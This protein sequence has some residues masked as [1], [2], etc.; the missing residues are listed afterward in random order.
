MDRISKMALSNTILKI[1]LSFVICAS[2]PTICFAPPKK[3]PAGAPSQQIRG[4]GKTKTGLFLSI[5][6]SLK[7]APPKVEVGEKKHCVN[8][9]ICQR[10]RS[11]SCRPPEKR[12]D[13]VLERHDYEPRIMQFRAVSREMPPSGQYG[14]VPPPALMSDPALEVPSMNLSRLTPPYGSADDLSLLRDRAGRDQFGPYSARAPLSSSRPSGQALGKTFLPGRPYACPC[15]SDHEA[16]LRVKHWREQSL[17]PP[18]TLPPLR[19]EDLSFSKSASTAQGSFGLTKFT[20]ERASQA[21]LQAVPE[22]LISEDELPTGAR[23]E[24]SCPY[25]QSSILPPVQS[26]DLFFHSIDRSLEGSE[27][28]NTQIRGE[29]QTFLKTILSSKNTK[30]AAAVS[31]LAGLV[32]FIIGSQKPDPDPLDDEFEQESDVSSK[33]WFKFGGGGLLILGVAALALTAAQAK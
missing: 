33:K 26:Q 9:G 19:T 10:F 27:S 13:Q 6:S 28:S 30:I 15:K 4:P 17:P 25:Q 22:E 32:L 3:A 16:F 7:K 11:K 21:V 8:F 23:H 5:K 18:R 14:R 12:H 20:P 1:F 2:F 24:A 31:A 29:E